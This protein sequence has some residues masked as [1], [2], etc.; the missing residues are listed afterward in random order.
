MSSGV[1]VCILTASAPDFFASLINFK[2]FFKEPEWLPESSA[3]MKG[4]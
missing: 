3:I 2:A 1:Y 4:L